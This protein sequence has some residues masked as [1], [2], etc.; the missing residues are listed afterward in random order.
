MQRCFEEGF[1]GL[2]I[3]VPGIQVDSIALSEV[4]HH[5]QMVPTSGKMPRD[6]VLIHVPVIGIQVEVEENR[7]CFPCLSLAHYW[8]HQG[9]A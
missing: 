4:L 6:V 9:A 7:N 5:F 3:P 1:Y 2:L 8:T